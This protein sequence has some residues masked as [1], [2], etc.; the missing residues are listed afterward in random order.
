MSGYLALFMNY[1]ILMIRRSR[2]KRVFALNIVRVERNEPS[3]ENYED[4]FI[5]LKMYLLP[6]FWIVLHNF[7][8]AQTRQLR[9]Y[10]LFHDHSKY[11]DIII[12]NFILKKSNWS[13]NCQSQQLISYQVI[14][15]FF[16]PDG[17]MGKPASD[18]ALVLMSLLASNS[19]NKSLDQSRGQE[20]VPT[21]NKE[22]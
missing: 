2:F 19:L 20:R 3:F 12:L 5:Y 15:F 1:S 16:S 14:I 4:H 7:R 11:A 9:N 17:K 10:F 22:W 13:K 21:T 6:M 8:K 18:E